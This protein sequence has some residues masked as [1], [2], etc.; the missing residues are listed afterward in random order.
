[1]QNLA[2]IAL[3]KGEF[4]QAARYLSQSAQLQSSAPDHPRDLY[5]RLLVAHLVYQ[6]K[7]SFRRR[8]ILFPRFCTIRPLRFACLGA[9]ESLAQLHALQG[10]PALAER[11]FSESIRKIARAR[12]A[13]EHEDFRLSF[14]SSAIRFYDAYI[15]FLIGRTDRSMH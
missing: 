4:D 9:Q 10:K 15:D 7:R 12:D 5:T 3:G 1:L 13:L 8:E 2:L 6:A 11:E 14:L